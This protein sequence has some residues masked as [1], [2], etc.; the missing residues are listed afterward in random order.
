MNDLRYPC[1]SCGFIV[2]TEPSGSYEMC[3][4][5][6]WEDDPVQLKYFSMR[7]GANGGS[8]WDY[9]QEIVKEISVDVKEY[10]GYIRD[11]S[12]RPLQP[13]EPKENK[14]APRSGIEYFLSATEE[15]RPYYWEKD[16]IE[17]S[18]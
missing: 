12:W 5:C 11:S 9:Q 13:K 10:E 16:N 15:T 2:F 4:I 3:S 1:P 18:N 14:D 17:Q 8:L 7:G 6:G